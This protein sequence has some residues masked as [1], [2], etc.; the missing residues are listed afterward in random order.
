MQY[1]QSLFWSEFIV[2]HKLCPWNYCTGCRKVSHCQQQSYSGLHSPGK[3]YSTYLWSDSWVQTFHCSLT[4]MRR[5]KIVTVIN[6]SPIEDNTYPDNHLA[7][8]HEV[9]SVITVISFVS[10]CR[11]HQLV[12]SDAWFGLLRTGIGI[13]EERDSK[14]I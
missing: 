7:A 1:Y 12:F 5:H 3:S 13:L 2:N 6:S 10:F 9:H 14:I 4:M 8:T 11:C